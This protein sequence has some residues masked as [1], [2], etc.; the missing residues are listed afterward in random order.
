M[1]YTNTFL[2]DYNWVRVLS[3]STLEMEIREI[4]NNENLSVEEK[5]RLISMRNAALKIAIDKI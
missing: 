5:E 4:M 1:K 3:T 2:D